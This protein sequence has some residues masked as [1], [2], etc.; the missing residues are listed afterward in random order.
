MALI[1]NLETMLRSGQDN[2]LLRYGLGG[3]YLK[4][5]EYETAAEHL[6]RAV[7]FDPNYSAAWNLLGKA[8]ASSGQNAEAIEAYESGIRVAEEKGDVQA[9][10]EMRVFLKRLKR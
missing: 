4:T 7:E 6:R 5:K 8:L 2:A 1:D 10:K 3:E 9:A